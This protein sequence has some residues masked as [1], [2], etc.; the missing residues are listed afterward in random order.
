MYF[1]F[2]ITSDLF[3]YFTFDSSLEI[4]MNIF[5]CVCVLGGGGLQTRYTR[6]ITRLLKRRVRATCEWT[7]EVGSELQNQRI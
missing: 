6:P 1:V 3:A 7:A 2:T 5:F 4:G